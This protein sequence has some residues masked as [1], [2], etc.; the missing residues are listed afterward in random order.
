MKK[1]KLHTSACCFFAGAVFFAVWAFK[2]KLPYITAEVEAKRL[3]RDYVS[4]T[5]RDSPAH[6]GGAEGG[7]R[8]SETD[9]DLLDAHIDF[10]GL[11]E[12]NTDIVGWIYIPG[13]QV[14]YPILQ[15]HF[16]DE[17]YLHHAPKKE[18]NILGSIYMPCMA[19]SDFSD[20][21]TVLFGHN[22]RS[23]QMFGELSRYSEKNFL[24]QYPHLYVY[25]PDCSVQY[26]IYSA[27]CCNVEDPVYRADYQFETW[28]FR[29]FIFHTKRQSDWE[30]R[31]VP[32]VYDE[33][34]TLSTCTDEGDA[35]QRYVVNCVPVRKKAVK[36][37][38]AL[39]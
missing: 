30:P 8:H 32:S 26:E 25:L 31:S 27:Y 17:Y 34:L 4:G 3:A 39:R 37:Q 6:E 1:R 7:E 19:S 21:H 5:V 28:E 38:S 16:D 29:D 20:P 12:L 23:G 18:E 10:D 22:M 33:I 13:T 36:K 2:E 15:H 35:E 9:H 11:W 14:N 24:R